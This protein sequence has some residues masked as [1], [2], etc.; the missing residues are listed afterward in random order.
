MPPL[1][2]AM[3]QVFGVSLKLFVDSAPDLAYGGVDLNDCSQA[4]KP[5]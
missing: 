3:L 2:L 5:F 1:K 4:Q